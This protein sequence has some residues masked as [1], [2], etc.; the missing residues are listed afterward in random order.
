MDAPGWTIEDEYPS[1]TS[2]LFAADCTSLETD[3]AALQKLG[4]ELE[5]AIADAEDLTPGSERFNGLLEQ[6]EAVFRVEFRSRTLL[7]SLRTYV[8]CM[9]STD[10]R[11]ET[12]QRCR[13]RLEM[14]ASRMAEVL[15]PVDQILLRVPDG[16]V[17]SLSQMNFGSQR[18]F[19]LRHARWLAD[20]L[21][22]LDEERLIKR[23]SL[24][25]L[26]AWGNLYNNLSS[27]LTCTLSVSPVTGT[28]GMARAS[29]LLSHADSA[30][31]S[32]AFRAINEAWSGQQD[33]CAAII[34]ALSGWRGDVVKQRS[35]KRPMAILDEPLHGAR[36]T[37]KTLEAMMTAVR[38]AQPDVRASLHRKSKYLNG[39]SG[40]LAPC[41]LMA[42]PPHLAAEVPTSLAQVLSAP[43]SGVSFAEAVELIENAF[44]GV[45]PSMGSFVRM[46]V[47]KGWIEGRVLDNKRPGAYCTRFA[48]SRTPRVYLT[49]DGSRKSVATLAHELGHAYH[50]WV[51]R[52]LSIFESAYP[53]TL[54]ETASIFAETLL[55]NHMTCLASSRDDQ[56]SVLWEAAISAERFLINIPARFDFEFALRERR[57]E[58]PLSPSDLCQLMHDSWVRN[59]ADALSAMDPLFWCSKLHFHLASIAFYNFPYTF[60]YLFSLGVYAQRAARGADFFPSYVA[61][62]RDTGR[63]TA[64]DLARQHLGVDLEAPDF[65]R[66]AIGIVRGQLQHFS[67][68]YP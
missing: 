36:I 27:Q 32:E 18:A 55:D 24:H 21:L 66:C 61:L 11:N 50:G 14:L 16:F 4:S 10:P 26:S 63:M 43:G 47:D 29:A 22:S 56:R 58:G 60:G 2:G 1:L 65:W 3:I 13:G 6:I 28:M 59:Y 5:E 20:H 15:A 64:E 62:L 45:D 51:M 40:P 34:N 67:Q 7:G 23:L 53:M 48:K 31:R 30:I 17:E 33:V 49:F 41:D 25:G 38:E 19:T 8:D 9:L 35:Q 37:D 42:P 44:A 57:S 54:A 39:A 12:A 68:M 46:M 52:D